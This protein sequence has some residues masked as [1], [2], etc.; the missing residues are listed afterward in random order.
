MFNDKNIVSIAC[1]LSH[2][3]FLE[4]NGMVWSCGSWGYGTLVHKFKFINPEQIE[5]KK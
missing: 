2:T 5:F 3:L 4:D 1:G